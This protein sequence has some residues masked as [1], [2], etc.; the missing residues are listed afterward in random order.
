[1]RDKREWQG[2]RYYEQQ[3]ERDEAIAIVLAIFLSVAAV[4]AAV[5]LFSIL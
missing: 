2:V 1:M 3:A 4:A 5:W